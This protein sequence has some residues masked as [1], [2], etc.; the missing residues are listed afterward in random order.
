MSSDSKDQLHS[1]SAQIKYYKDY[2]RTHPQYKLVD[3]YAD[4]GI[5][6]TEMDKRD[7]LHRL[8]RDCEKGKIKRVIVKSVSRFARNTEELIIAIRRLKELG[9]SM[10]AA[11]SIPTSPWE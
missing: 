7:E 2:E 1:F 9:V 8:F 10:S 5:T 4:E 3:I 11:P 6:G